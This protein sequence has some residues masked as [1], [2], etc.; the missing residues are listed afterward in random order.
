[1]TIKKWYSADELSG[2]A[3]M[4][5]T[6]REVNELALKEGWLKKRSGD[7]SG[8]ISPE[9]QWFSISELAGLPGI[10]KS[11]NKVAAKAKREGWEIRKRNGR[12]GGSE[13]AISSL[14][15][16]AQASLVFIS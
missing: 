9:E 10:P 15:V 13:Y 14:P 3:G 7:S 5:E 2:L 11:K 1:M 16:E 8:Y 12:G 4:P 6:A